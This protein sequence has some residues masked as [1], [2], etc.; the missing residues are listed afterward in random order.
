MEEFSKTGESCNVL[1][2]A[3]RTVDVTSNITLLYP[4]AFGTSPTGEEFVTTKWQRLA[5]VIP[6]ITGTVK[7]HSLNLFDFWKKCE[8]CLTASYTIACK[9]VTEGVPQHPKIKQKVQ[10]ARPL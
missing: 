6:M 8:A 2:F 1:P 10:A 7:F 4:S 3:A 5:S 9:R